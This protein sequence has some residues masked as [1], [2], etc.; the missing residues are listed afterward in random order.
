MIRC[1]MRFSTS[2]YINKI[3]QQIGLLTTCICNTQLE[4]SFSRHFSGNF[5]TK[6]SLKLH[7]LQNHTVSAFFSNIQRFREKSAHEMR[8]NPKRYFYEKQKRG[9]ASRCAKTIHSAKFRRELI[10]FSAVFPRRFP[11]ELTPLSK[12]FST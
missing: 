5:S 6:S 8:I 2:T 11:H 3:I 7:L 12:H 4:K 1:E 9:K 10:V